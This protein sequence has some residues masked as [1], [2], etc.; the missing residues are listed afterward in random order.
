[1]LLGK[2][3]SVFDILS[4]FCLFIQLREILQCGIHL[5]SE[6]TWGPEYHLLTTKWY[7]CC[8]FTFCA[9][10]ILYFEC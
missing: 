6:T 3:I 5:L 8:F 9:G 1:M 7:Y 10:R 4:L 2:S